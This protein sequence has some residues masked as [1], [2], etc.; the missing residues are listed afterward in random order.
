[1]SGNSTLDKVSTKKYMLTTIDNPYDPYTQFDMWYGFDNS[2]RIVK[3]SRVDEPI[4]TNCC[5]KLAEYAITSFD[6]TDEEY[7]YEIQR[8]VDEIIEDD[9]LHLYARAYEPNHEQK[10]SDE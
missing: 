1:M 7:A 8:A 10:S 4:S 5:G 6:M 3:G 2:I 9:N